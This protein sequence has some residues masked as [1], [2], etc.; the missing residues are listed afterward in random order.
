MNSE[1]VLIE[2]STTVGLG[3]AYRTQNPNHLL[4]VRA[5]NMSAFADDPAHFLRWL[6]ARSG[7]IAEHTGSALYSCHPCRARLWARTA[8]A[9]PAPRRSSLW[10][11]ASS[12]LVQTPGRILATGWPLLFAVTDFRVPY[13]IRRTR[14][15]YSIWI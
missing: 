6:R 5:S 11:A 13:N 4:N 14:I 1:I 15:I 3:L 12:W 9:A 10:R 8:G 2:R 7:V